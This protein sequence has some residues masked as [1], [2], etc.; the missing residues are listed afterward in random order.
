LTVLWTGAARRD[1]AGIEAFIAADDP[2]AAERVARFIWQRAQKLETF[3]NRG[4]PGAV[5]GTR[6][7]VLTR[8][9]YTIVYRVVESDTQIL[10]IVHQ[11]RH[12]PP[13]RNS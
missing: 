6:E 13:L 4:R 2:A 9:P 1:L 12:W 7:L 10:N 11:S 5:P 8:Y 3:P